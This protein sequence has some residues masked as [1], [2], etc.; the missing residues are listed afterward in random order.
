MANQSEGE[1]QRFGWV[2]DQVNRETMDARIRTTVS[3]P[4]WQRSLGMLLALGEPL[5]C[6]QVAEVGCGSGTHAL[7]LN[8]LG[9]TT[10]LIDADAAALA[11]AQAAFHLYGRTGTFHQANVLDP[12]PAALV[13]RFHYVVSGGLAEHFRGPDRVTCLA[14]HRALLRPGGVTHIGVPNRLSP[15]YQL[16][17]GVR[18]LTG[19]WELDVEVPFSPGELRALARAAGFARAV[20][21]GN[22]PLQRDA[23]DYLLGLASALLALTPGLRRRLRQVRTATATPPSG[24]DS[25]SD[26]GAV[27]AA[28]LS[29]VQRA[30]NA[31][32]RRGLTD[33]FSAGLILHGFG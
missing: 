27:V 28:A 17:R 20:V 7:T 30:R 2:V 19:T 25:P 24:T 16:V 29:A 12:V 1:V 22:Y 33:V 23:K 11:V 10:T 4:G 21:R 26:V 14:F 9:A 18:I 3:A 31:P 32:A 15:F 6:L 5:E 8:L 13:G